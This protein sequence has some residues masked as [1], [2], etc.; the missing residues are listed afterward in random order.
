MKKIKELW[1]NNKIV[2]VL[3]SILIIC[4]IAITV[5]AATYFFG[6]YDSVYGDRLE[7]IED[8][9]ITD[10]IKDEFL[11]FFKDNET[12][13]DVTF[14]DKGKVIYVHVYFEKDVIKDDAKA[15]VVTS[16]DSLDEKIKEFYDLNFIIECPESENSDG[17]ISIGAKNVISP[18]VVW[19]NDTVKEDET[20]SD[21]EGE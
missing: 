10:E 7:G 2:I 17:Y 13:S 15:L 14:T 4:F 3:V 8:Y 9:E 6:G 5:V 20:A 21:E 11:N 1:K 18:N 16:L 12:V 19:T